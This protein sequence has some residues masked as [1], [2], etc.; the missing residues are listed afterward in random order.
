MR[1]FFKAFIFL[2]LFLLCVFTL[3][4]LARNASMR[5]EQTVSDAD[6]GREIKVVRGDTIYVRLPAQLG[7]GYGWYVTSADSQLLELADKRPK[8]ESNRDARPGA[9]ETEIFR[10]VAKR[11]G[12]VR[13]EL[14]YM[15]SREPKDKALKTFQV[16]VVIR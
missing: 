8:I 5:A 7:T 4:T 3:T 13:L 6:N 11:T 2:A 12:R 1:H 10:F 14:R 15:R 9:S 16:I